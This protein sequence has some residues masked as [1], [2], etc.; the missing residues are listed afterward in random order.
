MPKRYRKSKTR[1]A[2]TSYS[3]QPG[4]KTS[5]TESE[6]ATRPVAKATPFR[7]SSKPAYDAEKYVIGDLIRS[8]M[9][10]GFVFLILII[11]YFTIR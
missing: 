3:K 2:S 9:I 4:A 6:A 5:S 1:V 7:T 11:L 10:G 8:A